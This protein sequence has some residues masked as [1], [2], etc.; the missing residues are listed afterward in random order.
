MDTEV[1]GLIFTQKCKPLPRPARRHLG[2]APSRSLH[3]RGPQ[4]STAAHPATNERPGTGYAPSRTFSRVRVWAPSGH[5]W[6]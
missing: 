2:L 5:R 1:L 6:R 3:S 4:P